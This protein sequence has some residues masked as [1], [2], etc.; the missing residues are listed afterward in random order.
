[1]VC[2]VSIHLLCRLRARAEVARLDFGKL[3]ECIIQRALRSVRR[4]VAIVRALLFECVLFYPNCYVH[5]ADRGVMK[6][7]LSI[8]FTAFVL[9]FC[10]QAQA[11][12]SQPPPGKSAPVCSEKKSTRT[13]CKE[14]PVPAHVTVSCQ[15]YEV[16]EHFHGMNCTA[17]AWVNLDG[18]WNM[19]DPSL[20]TYYWASIVDG[21]EYY[22]APMDSES[23][24]VFCGL[25]RQ[26]Y[27]RV[28]AAGGTAVTAF[29]CDGY[30]EPSD[31]GG[32]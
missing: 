17:S 24:V 28:S 27:V 26:G 13:D 1:M 14:L 19:I 32:Q 22:S 25:S 18:A 21:Q 2:T 7:S 20:L 4:D 3:R 30:S 8:G 29:R 16:G 9:L 11:Q 23:A 31:P 6:Y 12:F 5:V 15:Y 10:N